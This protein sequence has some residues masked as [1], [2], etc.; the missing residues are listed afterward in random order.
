MKVDWCTEKMCFLSKGLSFRPQHTVSLPCFFFILLLLFN[1]PLDVFRFFPF[2][3]QFLATRE[4]GGSLLHGRDF[5]LP[6]L[7]RSL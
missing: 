1:Q 5:R 7:G 3:H 6:Q 2:S 4:V